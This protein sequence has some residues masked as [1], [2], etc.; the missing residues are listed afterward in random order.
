MLGATKHI[1][2]KESEPAL[3]LC[4]ERKFVPLAPES[5]DS[6]TITA[7]TMSSFLIKGRRPSYFYN[8]ADA[9][10]SITVANGDGSAVYL[11]HQIGVGAL[12]KKI[13][14]R[15]DT[16]Q[17][18]ICD[19]FNNLASIKS[20]EHWSNEQL[21]TTY[22]ELFGTSNTYQGSSIAA[23][24]SVCKLFRISDL[25][26]CLKNKFLSLDM[27]EDWHV[28]IYWE[29]SF[30]ISC[31]G[32]DVG[33]VSTD[34]TIAY[35]RLIVEE[36]KMSQMQYSAYINALPDRKYT[37]SSTDWYYQVGT[38]ANVATDDNMT[39]GLSSY[40]GVK[41]VVFDFRTQAIANGAYNTNA[42]SRN[43][44]NI[45]EYML[46]YNGNVLH[47]RSTAMTA[48]NQTGV[49][50]G[51]LALYEN[52]LHQGALGGGQSL[53][54]NT[55]NNFMLANGA[56][57]SNATIGTFYGSINLESGLEG[58]DQVSGLPISNG[59]LALQIKHSAVPGSAQY[60][61]VYT[62]HNVK[63]ECPIGGNWTVTK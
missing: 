51:A 47:S 10:L 31:L 60:I 39:L 37:N 9:V 30:L 22:N 33:L 4:D 49:A 53:A 61:D 21:G 40:L 44:A 24:G 12:I 54:P 14:V 15:T 59:S 5:N 36:Y 41:N 1:E 46:N 57:T 8:T 19:G 34:I 62:E 48:P 27:N 45:S 42:F 43:Q 32:A 18:S 3:G 38:N 56:S 55:A 58:H 25:I 28:E 6:A 26:G 20:T 11:S 23:G 50:T 2:Y 16:T 29:N 35:P 52:L 7:G 13:I 63:F 17:L